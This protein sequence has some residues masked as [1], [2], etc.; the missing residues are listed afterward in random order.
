MKGEDDARAQAV[1]NWFVT[2]GPGL[3]PMPVYVGFVVV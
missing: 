3:N 2:G 1:S